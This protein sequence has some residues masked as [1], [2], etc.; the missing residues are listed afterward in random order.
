[1]AP[2]RRRKPISKLIITT[3]PTLIVDKGVTRLFDQSRQVS[4]DDRTQ[5]GEPTKSEPPNTGQKERNRI[6][7]GV[8]ALSRRLLGTGSDCNRVAILTHG[9]VSEMVE[10]PRKPSDTVALFGIDA[11]LFSIST[12][13]STTVYPH[14]EHP[15]AGDDGARTD[16]TAPGDSDSSPP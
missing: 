1:M 8:S 14:V 2:F 3:T 9:V 16:T 6:R 10:I 11:R 13:G 12:R 7:E 15:A 5:H 4:R